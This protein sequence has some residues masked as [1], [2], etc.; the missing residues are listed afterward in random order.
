M[1]LVKC[2]ACNGEGW[3]KRGRLFGV[4]SCTACRGR[5][6]IEQHVTDEEPTA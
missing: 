6:L 2:P 5:G 4:I 3:R 1:E